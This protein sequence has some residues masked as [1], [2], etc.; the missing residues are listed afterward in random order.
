VKRAHNRENK[1]HA[2]AKVSKQSKS[3]GGARYYGGVPR[4]I[5]TQEARRERGKK[6]LCGGEKDVVEDMVP[7]VKTISGAL[8]S[9]ERYAIQSERKLRCSLSGYK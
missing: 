8:T 7:L 2:G 1:G 3:K 9:E 6:G 4:R 5:V